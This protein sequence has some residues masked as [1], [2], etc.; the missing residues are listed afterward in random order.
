M[1]LFIGLL[2][3]IVLL[4]L[5]FWSK[6]K[7]IGVVWYEWLLGILGLALLLFT[8]QNYR[9]SVAEFEPTAPGMFLLVFGLPG[10]VLMVVSILLAGW[11]YYRS[12]KV[13]G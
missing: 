2:I 9:A 3:G 7:K 12:R 5:A 11:R 13:S 10:L 6:S 1:W 8:F 4:L